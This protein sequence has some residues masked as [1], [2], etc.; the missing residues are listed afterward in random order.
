[1]RRSI[2]SSVTCLVLPYF[3]KFSHQQHDFREKVFVFWF[4]L[5]LCLK[6]FTFL[7][8]CRKI[9]S[10]LY[11]GLYVKCPF[12]SPLLMIL[13][14][15]RQSFEKSSN[16]IFHENP[17]IR[18]R[19]VSWGRTDINDEANSHFSH[20]SNASKIYWRVCNI[21]HLQ[22]NFV[23]HPFLLLYSCDINK[24]QDFVTLCKTH[25]NCWRFHL[26]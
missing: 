10:Q 6:H 11:V 14:F 2:L 1:M 7:E 22:I 12:F 18:S 4:S 26:G 3:S 25:F 20:F 9:L 19:V 17:T 23:C 21:L 15:S 24:H 5:Q 16:I 13:E 8:E